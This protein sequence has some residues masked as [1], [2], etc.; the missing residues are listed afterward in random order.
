MSYNKDFQ[1]YTKCSLWL[2]ALP[3]LAHNTSWKLYRKLYILMSL[4]FFK[5]RLVRLHYTN[6]FWR[7][8][9]PLKVLMTTSPLTSLS[10]LSS[11]YLMYNKSF[12]ADMSHISTLWSIIQDMLRSFILSFLCTRSMGCRG[13]VLSY[14]LTIH[15]IKRYAGWLK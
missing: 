3:V 5:H 4:V 7:P 15:I 12:C 1:I 10:R 13:N 8:A 2:H 6:R 14:M 9:W 11:C